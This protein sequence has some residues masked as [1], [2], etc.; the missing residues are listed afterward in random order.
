MKISLLL[1]DGEWSPMEFFWFDMVY[2]SQY[3]SEIPEQAS[4]TTPL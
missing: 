3:P 1:S 4:Q 2:S